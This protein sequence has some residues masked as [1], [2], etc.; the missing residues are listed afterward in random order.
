MPCDSELSLVSTLS[1]PNNFSHGL[2]GRALRIVV[3]EWTYYVIVSKE[4][5]TQITYSGV[6]IDLLQELA[7]RLNFSYTLTLHP[8]HLSWGQ[9]LDNGSWDG[10]IGILTRKEADVALSIFALTAG[11]SSVVDPTSPL[12]HDSSVIIFRKEP[13]GEDVDILSFFLQPFQTPVY[14]AIG[15]C[16]VS[17]L[18]L[19]LLLEK[20]RWW[21]GGRQRATSFL[22]S[23]KVDAEA[24]VAGLVQE[25][26][27]FEIAFLPGRVLMWAWLM[28]GVV[29]ASVYSSKLTSSLTVSD[30]AL[31]FTSLSQLLNQDTYTWGV[32]SGVHLESVL[33]KTKNTE[34]QQFYEGVLRFAKDDPTVNAPTYDAHKSKV[35]SGR[36]AFF[37]VESDLYNLWSQETCDLARIPESYMTNGKVFYLQKNS[38]YTPMF[39]QVIDRMVEN[40]LL[41]YWK[42]KWQPSNHRCDPDVRQKSRVIGL[43]E[44]QAAFYLAGVGAGLAALALGMECLVYKIRGN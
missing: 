37:T 43:A 12:A 3:K 18:V 2:G 25:P 9:E 6:L 34:Y 24:L 19:L 26:V 14:V 36:Y 4:N 22:H 38:P 30:Q 27:H 17:V 23:L 28:F 33:K 10:P 42:R 11:R 40:G 32:V 5:E 44:T 16:F 20:C 21:F 31:P 35:M 41:E 39:N 13:T 1:S 29:L 8:R 7:T 15:G